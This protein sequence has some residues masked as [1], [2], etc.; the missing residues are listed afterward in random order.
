MEPFGGLFVRSTTPLDAGFELVKLYIFDG[1]RGGAASA[2]SGPESN[3]GRLLP[4]EEGG[5]AFCFAWAVEKRLEMDCCLGS[6][7]AGE[8][9]RCRVESLRL[10]LSVLL[11]PGRLLLDFGCGFVIE[12][13]SL[14]TFRLTDKPR[15][16]RRCSIE[17]EIALDG[18]VWTKEYR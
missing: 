1:V 6:G 8:E 5:R 2:G 12:W 3:R 18:V 13:R 17:G 16:H 11:L 9:E 4:G 15:A 7:A 10:R 14:E